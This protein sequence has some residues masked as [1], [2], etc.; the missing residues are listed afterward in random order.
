MWKGTGIEIERTRRSLEHASATILG[1]M[2]FA[3]SRLDV[4]LALHIVWSN[5]GSRLEELTR[6][7]EE[8]SFQKKLDFLKDLVTTKYNNHEANALYGQWLEDADATR[9]MRNDLV[10][11][12]WGIDS[13]KNEV[14]NVVG[15]PT[16]SE[17]RSK[18]YTTDEL[19]N[20]LAQ[21][22]KL[23]VRLA[24]LREKWPI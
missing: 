10:H 8:S 17:Q 18:G 23:E 15:L 6:R 3:F 2:I 14:V 22:D 12:R 21:L 11:G 1:R 7:F 24:E 19:K 13:M 9:T 20:A 5:D 4:A 16:S